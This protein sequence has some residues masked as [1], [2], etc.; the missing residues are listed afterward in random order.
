MHQQKHRACSCFLPVFLSLI[1]II[2][3]LFSTVW[4]RHGSVPLPAQFTPYSPAPAFSNIQDGSFPEVLNS[5]YA[6]LLRLSDGQVL[7]S[8]HSGEKAYPASLTKIM[9]VL[10]ALENLPGKEKPCTLPDGIFPPLYDEGASMAGFLPGETVRTKDLLYGA[11]L[12]SGADAAVALAYEVS[13]S[14][15]SFVEKMNQK[16]QELG[17]YDTHFENATGLHQDGHV[18]TADD[19]SLLLQYALKNTDFRNIFTSSRYSVPPTNLHPGGFTFSSTLS[20]SLEGVAIPDGQ[21]LG[22]KTG[23]TPEAGLCLASLAEIGGTEYLLITMGAPGNHQ[24]EAYHITD[25]VS[26]YQQLSGG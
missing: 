17:M 5:R 19:L 16:A 4:L 12:P 20:A 8:K 10:V 14:E 18:T 21:I 22:G 15:A 3:C 11:L 9:T 2:V 7:M 1:F 24:T 13:G 23:Y 25:A 26:V 6:L